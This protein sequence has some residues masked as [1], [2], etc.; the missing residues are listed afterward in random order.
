[1]SLVFLKYVSSA[2]KLDNAPL[3]DMVGSPEGALNPQNLAF[4][5][6]HFTGFI[7]DGQDI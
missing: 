2:T 3:K 4:V 7:A 6:L 5:K 1:M